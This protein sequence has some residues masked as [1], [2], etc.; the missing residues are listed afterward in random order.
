RSV[1]EL[2]APGREVR[3]A[4]EGPAGS[5]GGLMAKKLAS[6]RLIFVPV[7][8]LVGMG[9]LM[10]YSASAMQIFLPA[11]GA[12]SHPY[13]FLIKQGIAVAL[14]ALLAWGAAS[15]DYRKLDNPRL[16]AIALGGLVLALVAVLFRAPINGTRRW[17]DLKVMSVQPSEFAKVALVLALA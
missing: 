5:E 12:T 4:R 10:I 14:G 15:V 17:I 1:Q 7:I 6:D 8:L 9:L 2:R 16:I 13:Y 3:G 11:A